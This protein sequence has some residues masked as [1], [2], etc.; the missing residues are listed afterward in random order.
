MMNIYNASGE[1]RRKKFDE[2]QK[3]NNEEKKAARRK[4]RHTKLEESPKKDP[5]GESPKIESG[6]GEESPFNEQ[7]HKRLSRLRSHTARDEISPVVMKEILQKADI[8]L[9]ETFVNQL[10]ISFDS[11]LAVIGHV[12]QEIDRKEEED[13][14]LICSKYEM[15]KIEILTEIEHRHRHYMS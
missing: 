14:K 10:L 9:N 13:V 4:N 5:G 2:K 11:S 12:K 1:A 6:S 8:A 3:K 15:E 7:S